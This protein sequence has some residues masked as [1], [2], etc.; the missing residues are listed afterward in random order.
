VQS[1]D[2]DN[3]I[4]AGSTGLIHA[5]DNYDAQKGPFKSYCAQR[6]AGAMLDEIRMLTGSRRKYTIVVQRLAED[7]VARPDHTAWR[8]DL[9]EFVCHR[10]TAREQLVLVEHFYGGLTYRKISKQLG[11]TPSRVGQILSGIAA[12]LRVLLEGRADEFVASAD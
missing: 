5:I 10:L 6:I 4:S 9:R 11:V 3:L 12:K 2:Y 1:A 8:T 7:L